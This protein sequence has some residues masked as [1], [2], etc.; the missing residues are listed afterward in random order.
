MRSFSRIEAVAAPLIRA[1]IDTDLIISG[2]HCMKVSNKGFAEGLFANWRYLTG[3]DGYL[4][5][6]SGGLLPDETFVLNQPAYQEAEIL[7]AGVNFACG[8]S[9]EHAVW[10]LRD[11]GIRAVIAPSFGNIFYANCFKNGVLPVMLPSQAIEA[12]A[13][14][15]LP[16][17]QANKVIVDL[18]ETKVVAPGGASHDFRIGEFYRL[19]LL[20][21]LNPI[22]A[23]LRYEPDIAS[24]QA[25]DHDRRPWIYRSAA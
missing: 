24:F 14:E 21:G 9:R 23:V 8:S 2:D 12:I 18:V 7:L 6:A 1:N 16:D 11:W 5:D 22:E 17:P 25:C 19:V 10:A 13:A 20:E 3:P 15:V 4:R